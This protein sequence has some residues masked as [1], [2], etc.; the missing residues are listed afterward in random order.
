MSPSPLQPID[1]LM[2]FVIAHEAGKVSRRGGLRGERAGEPVFGST[3]R[4]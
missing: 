2:Q 1:R 3:G 4:G